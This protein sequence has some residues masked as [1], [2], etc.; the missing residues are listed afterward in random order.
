MSVRGQ[1]PELHHLE[2]IKEETELRRLKTCLLVKR[3][4]VKMAQAD[5]KAVKR[6]DGATVVSLF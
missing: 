5:K 2:K 1:S 3:A 4:G 6:E